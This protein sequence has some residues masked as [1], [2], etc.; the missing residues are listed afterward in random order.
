MFEYW[1]WK[2]RAVVIGLIALSV[3]LAV[4]VFMGAQKEAEL[5][6][7]VSTLQAQVQR[8]SQFEGAFPTY[9]EWKQQG[10]H[11]VLRL[12]VLANPGVWDRI[13]WGNETG[14]GYYAI[15]RLVDSEGQVLVPG[16]LRF[17][18][19]DPEVW[20]KCDA[21]GMA[22]AVE[23]IQFERR[24]GFFEYAVLIDNVL[25]LSRFPCDGLCGLEA[26]L[27]RPIR[28]MYADVLVIFYPPGVDG[29]VRVVW[30]YGYAAR[31]PVR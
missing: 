18:V 8:L 6:Q 7:Q 12:N 27:A 4:L 22:T 5:Q 1:S 16:V 14:G 10:Q 29:Y 25:K 20:F 21:R 17:S 15:I 30:D 9:A 24:G 26:P 2:E 23:Q 28:P 11:C 19:H 13:R 31:I 3:A